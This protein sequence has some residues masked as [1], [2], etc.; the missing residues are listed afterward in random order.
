M[1]PMMRLKQDIDLGNIS[2]IFVIISLLHF[3]FQITH[4]HIGRTTF[5]AISK[6]WTNIVHFL[7]FRNKFK[8]LFELLIT[9]IRPLKIYPRTSILIICFI[10]P[11]TSNTTFYGK[12][13]IIK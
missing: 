9:Q 5:Y 10:K 2:F 7:A 11:S 1:T 13:F 8:S 6:N 3:S 12:I 4:P